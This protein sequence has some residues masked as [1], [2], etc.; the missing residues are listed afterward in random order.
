[1]LRCPEQVAHTAHEAAALPGF[2]L[3][4]PPGAAALHPPDPPVARPRPLPVPSP[5]PRP[6]SSVIVMCAAGGRGGVGR[7]G[8]GG[9]PRAGEEEDGGGTVGAGQQGGPG[10]VVCGPGYGKKGGGD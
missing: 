9:E 5:P 6:P 8:Q 7:A 2:Q 4:V 3:R 1:M 10:L